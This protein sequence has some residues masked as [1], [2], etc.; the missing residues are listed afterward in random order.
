MASSRTRTW[1]ANFSSRSLRP[2]TARAICSSARVAISRSFSLS[3]FQLFV[4]RAFHFRH[5]FSSIAGAASS[6]PNR[7]V[8]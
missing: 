2:R 8:I 3:S 5:G 1:Q 6:Y 7:P 4:E